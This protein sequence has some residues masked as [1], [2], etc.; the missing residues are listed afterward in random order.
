MKTMNV[1]SSELDADIDK[2]VEILTKENEKFFDEESRYY[3]A[4]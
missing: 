3:L 2:T 4:D 1:L